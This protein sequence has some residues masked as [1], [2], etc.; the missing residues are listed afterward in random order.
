MDNHS[1][2]ALYP[3]ELTEN[4]NLP[5]LPENAGDTTITPMQMDEQVHFTDVSDDEPSAVDIHLE[6]P[7]TLEAQMAAIL[8]QASASVVSSNLVAPSDPAS[9]TNASNPP[10]DIMDAPNALPES[11]MSPIVPAAALEA[12]TY[13]YRSPSIQ[14]SSPDK[15]TSPVQQ[16]AS[17]HSPYLNSSK[18]Q[19]PVLVADDSTDDEIEFTGEKPGNPSMRLR[20]GHDPEVA[21]DDDSDAHSDASSGNVYLGTLEPLEE[22]NVWTLQGL[23]GG[24]PFW[25]NPVWPLSKE[26]LICGH[27]MREDAMRLLLEVSLVIMQSHIPDLLLQLSAAPDDDD[28]AFIRYIYVF[29]C[30]SAKCLEKAPTKSYVDWKQDC[31]LC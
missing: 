7:N 20:G 2:K 19:S 24:R 31:G 12:S 15:P 5:A 11:I 1:F 18:A 13:A 6:E 4:W 26:E 21:S 27:C 23:V 17:G 9:T 10:Q 14:P 30:T 16:S 3:D 25:V 29:T 22:Y 8:P 28:D